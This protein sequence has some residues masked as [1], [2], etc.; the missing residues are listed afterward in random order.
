MRMVEARDGAQQRRFAGSVGPEQRD[1][2][3]LCDLEV[4]VEQHLVRAVE[5]VEVVHL[6]GGVRATALAARPSA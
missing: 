4:H 6:Q 3:A 5:E 2:L 1:D